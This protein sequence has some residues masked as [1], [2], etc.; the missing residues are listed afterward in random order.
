MNNKNELNTLDIKNFIFSYHW[1][2]LLLIGAVG[3]ILRLIYFPYQLPLT[4]D[5]ELFFWYAIDMSVLGHIPSGYNFPNTAWSMFVSIFFSF[6]ESEKILDYMVLQRI[7][8]IVISVITI[9]PVYFLCRKFVSIPFSLLGALFFILSPRLIQD[10]WIGGTV[11][12][13][14]LLFTISLYFILSDNKKLIYASFSI[15]A[16]FTL[17][18]YEGMVLLIPFLIIFFIKHKKEKFIL[19]KLIIPIMIFVIILLPFAYLHA[20]STDNIQGYLIPGQGHDSFVSHGIIQP[21]EV[22][23]TTSENDQSELISMF[24]KGF[25]N[26]IQ[27]FGWI[28]IPLFTVLTPIGFLLLL[29]NRNYQKTTIILSLIFM[30]LPAFYA[31]SRDMQDTKYLYVLYPI[32]SL[33]SVIAIYEIQNRIKRPKLV[34]GFII[35]FIFLASTLFIDYQNLDYE[36]EIEAFKIAQEI[37]I[38][39]DGV[40]TYYPESQYLGV[41]TLQNYEFPITKNSISDWGAKE[42]GDYRKIDNFNSLEEFILE[43]NPKKIQCSEI[44]ILSST[45]DENRI[46]THIVI[47]DK[48]TRSQFLKDIFNGNIPPYLKEEFNSQEHGYNYNVK[49][50]KIDF[51][52][53]NKILSE[54]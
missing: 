22:Y 48:N 30:L 3:L 19:P 21:L 46:L 4:Q 43:Y 36:H 53:F 32:F 34:G 1:F 27:Y 50:Y 6:F 45:C 39:S 28:M 9:I 12:P 29:K 51:N 23:R 33:L 14:I 24:V 13:F 11:T 20:E 52:L 10:S 5:T 44:Q 49:V 18:R 37:S 35:F 26:L 17:I 16:L 47:D 7:L 38:I 2:I 40:N 31:Y 54:K 25:Y 8:G 42:F 41:S 15:L